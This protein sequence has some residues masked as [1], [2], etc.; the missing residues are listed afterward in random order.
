MAYKGW[1]GVRPHRFYLLRL[2]FGS[3]GDTRKD[4]KQVSDLIKAVLQKDYCGRQ[5]EGRQPGEG[6][7]VGLGW[8][9]KTPKM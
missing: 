7:E 2:L 4:F 9:G 3:Y 5:M 6:V 1:Q 8:T